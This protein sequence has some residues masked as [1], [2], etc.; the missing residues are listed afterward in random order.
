[1]S[2]VKTLPPRRKI[3]PAD[4]WDLSSLFKDDA[5]WERTFKKWEKQ[6]PGYEKFR[7]HL[8]DSAEM[9]AACLQFDSAIERA[10]ENLGTYAYLKA[11]EDQANSDYQRMKGRYTHAATKAG[12]ASSFI[13]PELMS[14]PAEKI[15]AFMEAREIEPWKLALERILRLG[16]MKRSAIRPRKR[17]SRAGTAPRPRA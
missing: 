11:S 9:L 10:G 8:G 12:E 4:T 6:I 7:G 15:K 5:G 2:K 16:D 1:M 14:I 13:R 3:K 17:C